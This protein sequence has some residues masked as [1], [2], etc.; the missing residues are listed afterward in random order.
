MKGLSSVA[1][2]AVCLLVLVSASI[3]TATPTYVFEESSRLC[4]V[5]EVD[6]MTASITGSYKWTPNSANKQTIIE[7][8]LESP[9]NRIVYAANLQNQDGPQQFSINLPSSNYANELG[10]Y[11]LCATVKNRPR[12]APP[13]SIR[14]A[15]DVDQGVRR[16]RERREETTGLR[17]L[18]ADGEAVVTFHD[19]HGNTMATAL[20]LTYVEMVTNLLT[21]I[22]DSVMELE[23]SLQ[24]QHDRTLRMRIT[25]ESTFSR[26]WVCGLLLC[27]VM[28]GMA[29]VQMKWL[30]SVIKRKKLI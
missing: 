9:S 23:T 6:E 15:F 11:R 21:S 19:H 5:E 4:F 28:A 10:E 14:I 25:A 29:W 12:S 3:A 13:G 16:F 30:R 17:K 26:V 7:L 1:V 8:T 24:H 20:P 22:V 18:T 27:S 2:V